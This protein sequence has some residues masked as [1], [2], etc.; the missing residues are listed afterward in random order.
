MSSRQPGS[1]GRKMQGLPHEGSPPNSSLRSS[2]C[3]LLFTFFCRVL[4]SSSRS[5]FFFFSPAV[6]TTPP[7]PTHFLNKS[8]I[9]IRPDS[10]VFRSCVFR[11][12]SNLEEEADH[13]SLESATTTAPPPANIHG[14]TTASRRPTQKNTNAATPTPISTT[15]P[16]TRES[17][18]TQ[19]ETEGKS[20][21]QFQC[22]G[23][24]SPTL[25]CQCLPELSSN[26]HASTGT[27]ATLLLA[28]KC[29]ATKVSRP[30]GRAPLDCGRRNHHHHHQFAY[31]V[32][33]KPDNSC[34]GSWPLFMRGL[35]LLDSCALLVLPS[36]CCCTTHP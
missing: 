7:L 17:N 5:F 27:L 22:Q 13:S 3:S 1:Q 14:T 24:G 31:E 20:E 4:S 35:S 33:L 30:R 19:D 18:K 26:Q 36:V 23:Q 2:T 29:L 10:S 15:L 28:L 6:T 8:D 34:A 9:R 25:Q 21:C 12:Y 16:K 32:M 11:A